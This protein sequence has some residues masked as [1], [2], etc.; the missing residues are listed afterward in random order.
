MGLREFLDWLKK[1]GNLVENN[2]PISP[3]FDAPRCA[4][5]DRRPVLFNDCNG[6]KAAMNVMNSRETLAK[7]LGVTPDGIIG[8]LTCTT[9]N[10][11]VKSVDDSPMF[12]IKSRPTYQNSR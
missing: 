10:G 3:I 5:N 6:M 8:K 11:E 7:A 4:Y 12:E 1:E 9:C 2:K